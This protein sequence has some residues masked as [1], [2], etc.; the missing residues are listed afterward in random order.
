MAW[1]TAAPVRSRSVQSTS[2][3]AFSASGDLERVDV[4]AETQVT[5]SCTGSGASS[6]GGVVIAAATVATA[7]A[8]SAT[9]T[10][11][12]VGQ[13]DA[14]GE[15]PG[16]LVDDADGEAEVLGVARASWSTPSRTPRYW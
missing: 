3:A 1:S 4:V 6:T 5:S 11:L 9:A 8:V 2:S 14:G 12:V 13:H 7:T 10:R 15:A 16:A